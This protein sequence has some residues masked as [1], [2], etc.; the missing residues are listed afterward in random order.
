[1]RLKESESRVSRVFLAVIPLLLFVSD[2]QS[3]LF[4]G[5][6]VLS[7]FGTTFLFFL[8]FSPLFPERLLKASYLL[9]TAVAAQ[10]I[11]SLSEG[12]PMALLS[13]FFLMPPEAFRKGQRA[14]A[15]KRALFRGVFFA[16]LIYY[17]GAF[18]EILAG[19]LLV[20]TFHLP[21]GSFFLLALAALIWQNQPGG[22]PIAGR[23]TGGSGK[24]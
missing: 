1:M 24:P 12:H 9:W 17:A 19:R 11:F 18:R 6:L 10:A 14:R 8:F 21:V 4:Y 23:K 15:L 7:V 20:W 3:A 16:I 5:G 2:T 13:L 22:G